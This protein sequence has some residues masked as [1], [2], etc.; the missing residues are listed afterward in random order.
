MT[1]PS[2]RLAAILSADIAGYL[3][4]MSDDEAGAIRPPRA[5]AGIFD[6]IPTQTSARN[7]A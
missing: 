3:R 1:E 6:N 7:A 2:R 4:L 5:P